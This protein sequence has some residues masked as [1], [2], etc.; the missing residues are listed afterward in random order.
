MEEYPSDMAQW[1][2]RAKWLADG[3]HPTSKQARAQFKDLCQFLNGNSMEE[4]LVHWCKGCCSTDEEALQKAIQWLIPVPIQTLQQC[5]ILHTDGVLLFQALASC[6]ET[7][8]GQ[9]G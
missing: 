1:K 4:E 3:F 2:Q 5:I 8:A 6:L 7:N 9:H